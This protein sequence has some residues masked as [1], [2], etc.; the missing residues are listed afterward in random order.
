[1]LPQLTKKFCCFSVYYTKNSL[2]SNC[3][4]RF[5]VDTVGKPAYIVISNKRT[6]IYKRGQTLEGLARLTGVN[7]VNIRKALR[8]PLFIGEQVIAQFLNVHPKELWPNRY[9]KNGN[10][11]HPHASANHLKPFKPLCK[12]KERS[13]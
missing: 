11:L 6:N 12:A 8:A 3:Y 5:S 2:I 9:D 10:P 1:M 4:G 13:M 7:S